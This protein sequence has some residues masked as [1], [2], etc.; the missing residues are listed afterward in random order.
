[1]TEQT[2]KGGKKGRKIGR[3]AKHPCHV[4]Y[5]L[6]NRRFR[7]KLKR[8]LQSSGKTAADEYTRLYK[9]VKAAK[10]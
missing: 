2:R 9:N 6:G 3:S 5:T 4:S 1:M 7:N 8:V 10:A